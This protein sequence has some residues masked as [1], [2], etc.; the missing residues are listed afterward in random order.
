MPLEVDAAIVRQLEELER[1]AVSRPGIGL[2]VVE[3][4][5]VAPLATDQAEEL[6][7]VLAELP[8]FPIVEEAAVPGSCEELSGRPC[9]R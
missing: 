4:G 2:E 7:D 8:G 1:A 9:A 6:L 5:D 3:D